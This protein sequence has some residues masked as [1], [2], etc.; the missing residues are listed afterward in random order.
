A[1]SGCVPGVA[2][3]LA[4]IFKTHHAH[5][6]IAL[7]H[8]K[9]GL[10]SLHNEV[11][12]ESADWKLWLHDRRIAPHEER[13]RHVI[14]QILNDS[15]PVTLGRRVPEEPTDKAQPHAIDHARGKEQDGRAKPHPQPGN[16]EYPAD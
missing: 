8:R 3:D 1:H 2:R 9:G 11:V 14:E 7:N 16:D 4:Y 15:L 10:A 12:D 13:D 5:D 6:P